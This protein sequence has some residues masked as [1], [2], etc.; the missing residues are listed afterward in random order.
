MI[1]PV[2]V[3]AVSGIDGKGAIS[4]V[5]PLQTAPTLVFVKEGQ[6]GIEHVAECPGTS[7]EEPK[8]AEGFLC[9]YQESAFGTKFNEG[10]S[11]AHTFGALL[12]FQGTFE[13]IA[14]NGSW[15]VTAS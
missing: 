7:V 1:T 6:A 15:A 10:N 11:S 4:F 12:E 2:K 8:A 9:L 13:G 3:P 14:T 5:I